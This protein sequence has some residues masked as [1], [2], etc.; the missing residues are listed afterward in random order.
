[1]ENMCKQYWEVLHVSFLGFIMSTIS[2]KVLRS[3]VV[4]KLFPK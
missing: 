1:M 2:L 3:P 4:E